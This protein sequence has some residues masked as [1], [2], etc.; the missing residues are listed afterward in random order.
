MYQHTIM[1]WKTIIN[2]IK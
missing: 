1:D 2:S